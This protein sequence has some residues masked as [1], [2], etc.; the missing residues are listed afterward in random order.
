MPCGCF[1]GGKKKKDAKKPEELQPLKPPK[2]P[3]EE[4]AVRGEIKQEVAAVPKS[5]PLNGSVQVESP[6]V[7]KESPV[8]VESPVETSVTTP[9][10]DLSATDGSIR[11]SGARSRSELYAKRREF[12]KPLYDVN[13]NAGGGKMFATPRSSHTLP[14]RGKKAVYPMG[15]GS[16]YFTADGKYIEG[17]PPPPAE[18][19]TVTERLHGRANEGDANGADGSGVVERPPRPNSQP[20]ALAGQWGDIVSE[21]HGGE[22]PQDEFHIKHQ[23]IIQQQH[24]PAPPPLPEPKKEINPHFIEFKETHHKILNEA[25]GSSH[26]IRNIDPEGD[27]ILAEKRL[28]ALDRLHNE[29]QEHYAKR[30]K[31]GPVD[32]DS[33]VH[34]YSEDRWKR[35]VE[36]WESE[37]LVVEGGMVVIDEKGNAQQQGL[38]GIEAT[39]VETVTCV[40][41]KITKEN[42]EE[43]VETFGDVNAMNALKDLNFNDNNMITVKHTEEITIEQFNNNLSPNVSSVTTI[44]TPPTP[45]L[46]KNTNKSPLDEMLPATI[47]DVNTPIIEEIESTKVEEVETVKIE[48]VEP[49]KVE[50]VE[51][52]KVE[53]VDFYKIE[54]VESTKMTE[55]VSGKVDGFASDEVKEAEPARAEEV[56]AVKIENFEQ[57][58]T[59]TETFSYHVDTNDHVESN[60]V[61]H[62]REYVN[63]ELTPSLVESFVKEVTG[64]IEDLHNVKEIEVEEDVAMSLE[65][66]SE[67]NAQV[68]EFVSSKDDS[69]PIVQ[70]II[71]EKEPPLNGNNNIPGVIENSTH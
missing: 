29:V 31:D 49:S 32:V 9:Q 57:K 44:V 65:L 23:Q 71:N 40:S 18:A 42:G 2:L 63:N 48:E 39:P 24:P 43:V 58:V 22:I 69:S 5:L 26:H 60:E 62:P 64:T 68:D 6:I 47:E 38:P 37:G 33:I 14:S 17:Q 53:E 67:H 19:E 13:V 12:F 66:E 35:M 52:S 41:K 4:P 50:E 61:E 16:G 34:K 70:K 8:A 15:D 20:N 21:E 11:S 30:V 45:N 28:T 51:P 27:K 56:A 59:T 36:M 3:A 54:D 1:G 7:A 55:V 25:D 10:S 46:D